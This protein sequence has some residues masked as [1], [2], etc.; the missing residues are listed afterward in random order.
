LLSFELQ[1][2]ITESRHIQKTRVI[3]VI[4]MELQ[5]GYAERTGFA[6]GLLLRNARPDAVQRL[7]QKTRELE[8]EIP[9]E[10]VPVALMT[11]RSWKVGWVD[12]W[13]IARLKNC[14]RAMNDFARKGILFCSS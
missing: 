13:K 1:G 4:N 2:G 12:G 11:A 10:K 3:N 14:K 8:A 9:R 6:A 7:L 5:D